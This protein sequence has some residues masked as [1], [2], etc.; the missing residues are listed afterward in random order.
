MHIIVESKPG[1]K[2]QTGYLCKIMGDLILVKL[3]GAK[4]TSLKSIT[5][6][7]SF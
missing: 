2:K 7:N 5:P 1:L 3:R 4:I 6:S